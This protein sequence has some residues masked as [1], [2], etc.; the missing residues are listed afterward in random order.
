MSCYAPLFVNVN[1]GGMQW[2]SDLIGYNTLSSFGSPSYYVQKMFGN[3]VGDQTVPVEANNLPTQIKKPNSK[4]SAK[5]VQPVTIPAMF[6]SATRD[7]KTRKLYL[8]V[9]N[10]SPVVQNINIDL[11]GS[12]KIAPEGSVVT[13]WSDSPENTNSITEP[14]KIVP[15]TQPVKGLGKN[16][17]RSF[18]AWSVTVLQLQLK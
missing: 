16:F 8:K 14:N 7:S 10:A 12:E 5:G 1:P 18:P 9:V 13:L 3:N 15:A 6:F 17:R 2:K 4:D 11:R